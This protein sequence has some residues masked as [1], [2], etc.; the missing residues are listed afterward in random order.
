M[1]PG[2]SSANGILML[3]V[4]LTLVY[5]RAHCMVIV[6][7]HRHTLTLLVTLSNLSEVGGF[8]TQGNLHYCNPHH[9]ITA[10]LSVCEQ[11]PV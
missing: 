7:I 10:P 2:V 9:G 4:R 5:N 11:E 8:Q 1:L 3:S 6:D